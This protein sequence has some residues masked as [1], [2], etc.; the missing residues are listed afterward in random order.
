MV[1]GAIDYVPGI[2]KAWK[3]LGKSSIQAGSAALLIYDLPNWSYEAIIIIFALICWYALKAIYHRIFGRKE[4]N[5]IKELQ[6]KLQATKTELL[7][8]KTSSI[9]ET[10]TKLKPVK[11]VK[12]ETN[13]ESVESKPI[14]IEAKPKSKAD[15]TKSTE[16]S[17]ETTEENKT[18][19]ENSD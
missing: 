15:E 10:K 7:L 6:N 16:I 1:Q 11:K 5:Q 17:N 8:A 13:K 14:T 12:L 9:I 2:T 19:K 4:R 18:E 3:S